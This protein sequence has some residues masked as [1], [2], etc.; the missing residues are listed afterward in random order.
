MGGKLV[1]EDGARQS[2]LPGAENTQHF[3]KNSITLIKKGLIFQSIA[4][5]HLSVCW[6][7][8]IITLQNVEKN[9]KLKIIFLHLLST[10]DATWLVN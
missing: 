8:V 10:V 7:F 9:V 2:S 3:N 5:L 1:V 4:A 6:L